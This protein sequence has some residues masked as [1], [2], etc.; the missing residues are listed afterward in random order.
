MKAN[1]CP[2]CGDQYP[3]SIAYCL[4]CY[5]KLKTIEI[6]EETKFQS[7]RESKILYCPR[8]NEKLSEGTR[9][10]PYCGEFIAKNIHADTEFQHQYDQHTPQATEKNSVH[11]Y[12]L[13][14][15]PYISAESW[16]YV[17]INNDKTI[18]FLDKYNYLLNSIS[19]SQITTCEM[20][21]ETQI[22][23][24]ITATRLIALGVL[25][26]LV[27]KKTTMHTYYLLL[28]YNQNNVNVDCLFRSD[29]SLGNFISTINRM[30]IEND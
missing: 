6:G 19:T 20:K 16:V 9:N 26:T 12:H 27:P 18:D 17:R 3:T 28:S 25:A 21:D 23:S 5:V 11:L 22:Q 2:K 13:G 1:V 10:C 24:R 15:H 14:G 8:C 4:N 7:K 29:T 30:R